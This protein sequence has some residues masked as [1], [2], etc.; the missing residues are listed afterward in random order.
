MLSIFYMSTFTEVFHCRVRNLLVCVVLLHCCGLAA[1]PPPGCANDRLPWPRPTCSGRRAAA[2]SALMSGWFSPEPG[3]TQAQVA[4]SVVAWA[5]GL[6]DQDRPL[7]SIPVATSWV[8]R[9]VYGP[10]PDLIPMNGKLLYFV[11]ANLLLLSGILRLR[12]AMAAR[13]PPRWFSR[14]LAMLPTA[15]L[16]AL[17]GADDRAIRLARVVCGGEVEDFTSVV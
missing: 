10:Q 13:S 6:L 14:T 2:V 1:A 3:R 12:H 17:R 16:A 8:A 4:A 15:W 7:G 5:W 11:M 9:F